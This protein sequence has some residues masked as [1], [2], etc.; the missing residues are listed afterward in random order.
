MLEGML[1]PQ[2]L[3]PPEAEHVALLHFPSEGMLGQEDGEDADYPSS[4]NH[5]S[6]KNRCISNSS[7]LSNIAIF[8][9]PWLW[10]KW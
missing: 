7:Y 8:P 10:E 2:G 5:G 1:L 6:V 3:G 4:H 9:L